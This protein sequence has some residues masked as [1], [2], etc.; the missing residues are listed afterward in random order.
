LVAVAGEEKDGIGE[1]GE[2]EGGDVDVLLAHDAES[3]QPEVVEAEA[4]VEA[5][6]EVEVEMEMLLLLLPARA[7]LGRDMHTGG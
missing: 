6:V 7:R 4:G 3:A 5:G 1:E 2:R